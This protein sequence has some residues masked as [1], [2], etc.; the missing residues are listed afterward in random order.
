M[1]KYLRVLAPASLV[2]LVVAALVAVSAGAATPAG[3]AIRVFG[4]SNG[5]GGGGKVLITGAIGDHGKTES[6]NKSGQPRAN[7]SYVL[8]K[9]TK[10]TI[11]LNKTT[12]DQKINGAFNKAKLDQ[13]TC[14]LSAAATGVLPFVTGTGLYTGISGSVRIAI[15][16]GFTLP[17]FTSGAKA[18]QCNTANST[19]PTDS[20]QIISGTGT[21]SFG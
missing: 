19:Q 6:A 3:G 2:A 11:L 17:R 7:G 5:L 8:L 14:S 10:G 20:V 1:S 9:L 15:A 16:A 13:A 21:V 18:G 12:L 4:V